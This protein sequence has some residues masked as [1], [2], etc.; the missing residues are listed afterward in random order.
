MTAVIAR[1]HRAYD[2]RLGLSEI[3]GRFLAYDEEYGGRSQIRVAYDLKAGA[4]RV[5]ASDADT[6]EPITP[7]YQVTSR[8]IWHTMVEIVRPGR[9]ELSS[10]PTRVYRAILEDLAKQED[11]ADREA[12]E[13]I[14]RAEE[15]LDAYLSSLE[16]GS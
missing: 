8:G 5:W 3:R 6:Y 4:Y 14:A 2:E 11:L 16:R 9:L 12:E 10:I 7:G 15:A 1:M 13:S